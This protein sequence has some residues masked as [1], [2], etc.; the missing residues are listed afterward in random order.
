MIEHCK[1][2]YRPFLTFGESPCH[3]GKEPALCRL[4]SIPLVFDNMAFFDN[5]YGF[6]RNLCMILFSIFCRL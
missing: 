4:F 1:Y 3:A 6:L 2:V 5:D